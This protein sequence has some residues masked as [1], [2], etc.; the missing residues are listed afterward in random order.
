M[1]AI[2]RERGASV[3]PMSVP[4]AA[5]LHARHPAYFLAAKHVLTAGFAFAESLSARAVLTGAVF[6]HSKCAKLSILDAAYAN[7][8]PAPGEVSVT[9]DVKSTGVTIVNA[10]H[11]DGVTIVEQPIA[12]LSLCRTGEADRNVRR[13]AV[14]LSAHAG[15]V[16]TARAVLALV[17]ELPELVLPRVVQRSDL[18][19][20]PLGSVTTGPIRLAARRVPAGMGEERP[21]KAIAV[22]TVG[23]LA[24]GIPMISTAIA[25]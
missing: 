6:G 10:A 22:G 12:F 17:A 2:P 25:K 11:A 5:V 20:L 9:I 8:P 1:P 13:V 14:T 3:V 19:A 4:N 15:E 23:L 21:S 16:V 18:V 24:A 7:A